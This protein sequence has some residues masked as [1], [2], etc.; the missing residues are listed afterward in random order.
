MRKIGG[1]KKEPDRVVV[2]TKEQLK[3]A[4]NRK[5]AYI[6]IQGDLARKLQWM[7]KLSSAKLYKL[8]G[9]LTAA[10]GATAVGVVGGPVAG[11]PIAAVSAVAV[12]NVTGAG[13]AAVILASGVTITLIVSVLKGYEVEMQYNGASM[14]LKRKI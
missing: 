5:E 3:S 7:G 2:T 4:V 14:C 1:K 11:V 8:A 9:V 13:V 12:T 10:A 6:E